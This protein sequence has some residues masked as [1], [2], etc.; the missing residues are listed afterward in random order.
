LLGADLG[1]GSSP[2]SSIPSDALDGWGL[3][4]SSGS[5][6]VSAALEDWY[7]GGSSEEDGSSSSHCSVAVAG[8]LSCIPEEYPVYR[9]HDP[10]HDTCLHYDSDLATATDLVLDEASTLVSSA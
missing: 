7:A 6:I 3:V 5:S 10:W 8:H 2:C 4:A 1:D 9:D